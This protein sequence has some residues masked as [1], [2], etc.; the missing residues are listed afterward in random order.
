EA[1]E[2]DPAAVRRNREAAGGPVALGDGDRFAG[3]DVD[4]VD[5]TAEWLVLPIL[6][7]IGADVDRAGICRPLRRPTVLEVAAADLPWRAAIGRQQEDLA[8]ARLGIT[9]TVE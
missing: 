8:V 2:R 9:A 5:L 3:V 6:F 7:A 1:D 4:A